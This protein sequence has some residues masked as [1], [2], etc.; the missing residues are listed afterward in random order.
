MPAFVAYADGERLE[1]LGSHEGV[2]AID[3]YATAWAE[4]AC[5]DE[6]D[7]DFS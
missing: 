1:D 4:D 7:I 3:A 5:D 2:E 6:C